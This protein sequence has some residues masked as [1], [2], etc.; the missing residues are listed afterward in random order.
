MPPVLRPC[1]AAVVLL[2]STLTT[3]AEDRRI[4]YPP[5]A[6]GDQV[7]VYHGV[8]VADPYRW[9]EDDVRNSPEVAEWVAAENK[10]TDAYLAAIPERERIRRRLT[11]LWNFAAILSPMKEGGRYYYLKNDG[12]QNQAVLYM[13]DSLDG[14]PRVLIDPEHSG[15]RTA[16]SPWPGWASATTASIW[17]T[18]A[19]RPAPIGRPGTSWR[20]PPGK[21]L[22]RRTE[23]DQVHQ[24]LVDQG[25]QGL[26]LQPLRRAEDRAP[27]SSR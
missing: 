2:S 11:E 18:A 24:R 7:D 1:L 22:A 12:L 27:S 4:E 16:P 9:L 26:F 3:A 10:V 19:P 21:L 25:R 5:T 13:M 20:S 23:V 14:E 15:P 8:K 6:R 17:P